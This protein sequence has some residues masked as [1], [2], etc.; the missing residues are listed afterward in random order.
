[1]VD[2]KLVFIEP[3]GP[4]GVKVKLGVQEGDLAKLREALE[5]KPENQRKKGEVIRQTAAELGIP[6]ADH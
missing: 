5:Q 1:M 4:Q 2:R 3:D 6:V